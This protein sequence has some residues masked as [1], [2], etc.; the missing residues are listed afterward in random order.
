MLKVAS[1]TFLFAVSSNAMAGDW[2]KYASTGGYVFYYDR[3][4]IQPE[5]GGKV[6]MKDSMKFDSADIDIRV[7]DKKW[8]QDEYDCKNMKY[9]TVSSTLFGIHEKENSEWTVVSPKTLGEMKWKIACKKN[10]M[11]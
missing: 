10:N 2:Y 3:A 8:S 9:R 6:K 4:S 7:L 5:D 11:Q 1:I